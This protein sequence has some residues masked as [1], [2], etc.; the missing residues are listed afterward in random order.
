MFS[1][2][3]APKNDPA[4]VENGPYR[5]FTLQHII[6][7]LLSFLLIYIL[8]RYI[9][10][11]QRRTRI[12]WVYSAYALL[13]ILNVLRLVW[14]FGTE[15]FDIKEDLP[16]QLCGIQMFTLPVALFAHGKAKD[17]MREFAFS[18]G[19]VGFVLALL[20]PFTTLFD[21]P[22]FHF[23]SMQS[24]IYHAVMGFIALSM[25]LIG[26]KPDITN[27]RKAY[28]SL[29]VF[30]ILTGVVNLLTGSNY[31]YTS[32]L[33]ITFKLLPWPFYIPFLLAFMLLMGRLPYYTYSLL[34][35]RASYPH[36]SDI[37]QNQ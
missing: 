14:G 20:M 6:L 23:R 37:H 35:H 24:L 11:K 33:P 15:K 12:K 25:P 2:F 31:L 8:I 27:V 18:Y 16:L 22:V 9:R 10:K 21:Y 36:S 19:T 1:L 30:A 3:F 32:Y 26:Y 4:L 5:P 13:V 17:Y 7:T 34:Q 28:I 29:L